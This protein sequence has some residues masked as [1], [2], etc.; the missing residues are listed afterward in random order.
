[1]VAARCMYFSWVRIL[2]KSPGG[3]L[4]VCTWIEAHPIYRAGCLETCYNQ[5]TGPAEYETGRDPIYEGL[6]S[7]RPLWPLQLTID[8]LLSIIIFL[9]GSHLNFLVNRKSVFITVNPV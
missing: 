5:D 8:Y 2:P 6:S 4:N 1:M 3:S 9:P 7:G